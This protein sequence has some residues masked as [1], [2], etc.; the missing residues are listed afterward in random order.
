MEFCARESCGKCAPCL[1]G[2][3]RGAETIDKIIADQDRPGN[4]VLLEDLCETMTSGSLC[5]MGGLTPRP[6]LSA[7]RFFPGDFHRPGAPPPRPPG[8]RQRRPAPRAV[9][10]VRL[11]R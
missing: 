2:S 10:A 6:V 3:V 1:I 9:R 11:T 7:L 4:L 8:A 5:A